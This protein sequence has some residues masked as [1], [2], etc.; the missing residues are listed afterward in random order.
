MVSLVGPF[1]RIP[2]LQFVVADSVDRR[3]W[4]ASYALL[5]YLSSQST[6]LIEYSPP[7]PLA[8]A[9][10]PYRIIDLGAGTGNLSLSLLPRLQ[11]DDVMVMTDMESVLPLLRRNTADWE[12]TESATGSEISTILVQRLEW[13]REGDVDRLLS[14]DSLEIASY[15]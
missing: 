10:T 6:S 4:E 11:R 7:S 14:M 3:I 9:R 2:I 8:A 12:K 1:D 15:R 13:G 5:A